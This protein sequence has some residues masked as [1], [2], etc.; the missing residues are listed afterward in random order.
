MTTVGR[1][2]AAQ[3]TVSGAELRNPQIRTSNF[4]IEAYFK[5]TP[6]VKDATVIQKTADSGYALRVN[7]AG[8]VTLSARD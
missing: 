6:G 8:G 7:E 4:L 5:T 2:G 1:R 3:R